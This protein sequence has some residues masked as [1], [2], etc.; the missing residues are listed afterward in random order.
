MPSGP[1]RGLLGPLTV[2]PAVEIPQLQLSDGGPRVFLG[3]PAA[4]GFGVGGGAAQP[5]HQ[6][7]QAAVAHE[8]VPTEIPASP[9]TASGS[10]KGASGSHKGASGSHKRDPDPIKETQIP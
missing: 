3:S 6:P 7:A 10:H 5:G 1:P 4:P 2:Q 8:G 9:K